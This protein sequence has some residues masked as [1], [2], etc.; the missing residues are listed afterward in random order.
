MMSFLQSQLVYRAMVVC[1]I[2]VFAGLAS[3]AQ[4][5]A[6]EYELKAAFLYNFASYVTWPD[7]MLMSP[8]TSVVFGV[9]GADQ[10][11]RH[12]EDIGRER[13][14]NGHRIEVRS[15]HVSDPLDDL[16]VLFVAQRGMDEAE[17]LLPAALQRSILTITESEGQ[18]HPDS[19]INLEVSDDRVQ[20]DVS[21]LAAEEAQLIIS[22]RL[23]QIAREVFG[24]N[25]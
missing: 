14:I 17:R 6:T 25:P 15:V 5:E 12:L 13:S 22:S 16:H 23:L 2:V 4:Y 20:F 10:L 1:Q 7:G 3:A 8:E 19:I 18:R 11:A 21:L 24:Q 9:V